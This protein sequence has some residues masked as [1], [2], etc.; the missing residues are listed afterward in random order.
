MSLPSFQDYYSRTSLNADAL[1]A[2]F[3]QVQIDWLLNRLRIIFKTDSSFS[4]LHIGCGKGDALQQIGAIFPNASL[5][6]H[7]DN[8]EAIHT[9]Q[10]ALKSRAVLTQSSPDAF[11]PQRR[12]DVIL[13]TCSL[14]KTQSPSDHLD[15]LQSALNPEA[16]L[17]ISDI[18]LSTWPLYI[19]H[20]VYSLKNK[21]AFFAWSENDFRYL[22]KTCGLTMINGVILKP[23]DFWRI[24]MYHVQPHDA[25]HYP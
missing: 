11:A 9:A 16:H 13:S 7:E 14:H 6:G 10:R 18:A 25:V 3:D 22:L 23:D 19:K 20:I 12:Y 8:A 15:K 5:H 21:G 24:Q 2:E 17:F 1:W 4:V